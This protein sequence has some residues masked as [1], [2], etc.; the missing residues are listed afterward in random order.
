[1]P[2]T[3]ITFVGFEPFWTQHAARQFSRYYG[4]E[5]DCRWLLWPSGNTGRMRLLWAT[6]TSRLVIRMGMPFEFQSETNRV[7]LAFV[8][9]VPWVRPV[10]YWMGYDVMD[11]LRRQESGQLSARDLAAARC[12]SHI[13]VTEHLAAE[14]RL[15]GLKTRNAELMGTEGS[16]SGLAPMPDRFRVLGYW[17]S[18]SFRHLG[19]PE[20]YEAARAMPETEFLVLGSD[21]STSPPAPGNVTFLGWLD[22]PMPAYERCAVLVRQIEHDSVPSGTI[23]E[24]LLLGRYVIY[25]Y[26]WPNTITVPY[27]DADS[28]TRELTELRARFDEGELPLN[29]AGREFT[30]V[31]CD[32]ER[33]AASMRSAFLDILAGRL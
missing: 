6:L 12:L 14:L 28:L 25:T 17:S 23:E 9:L 3:R 13:A 21:G 31:D 10:N 4:D 2:R 7:W 5:F 26:P 19:G 27:G 32:P 20:F 30:V 24:M 1:M 29:E 8:R 18:A 22:D 15:A 16:I 33:R 11:F